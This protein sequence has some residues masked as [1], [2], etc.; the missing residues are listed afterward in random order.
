MQPGLIESTK[1]MTTFPLAIVES[2]KLRKLLVLPA[3]PNFVLTHAT[4]SFST[5]GLFEFAKLE[6]TESVYARMICQMRAVKIVE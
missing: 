1:S 2:W 4:I 3:F 5:I 6:S